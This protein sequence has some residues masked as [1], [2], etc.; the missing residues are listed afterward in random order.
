MSSLVIYLQKLQTSGEIKV[1]D[2]DV[3]WKV[4]QME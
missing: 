1:K 4:T 2:D 3:G